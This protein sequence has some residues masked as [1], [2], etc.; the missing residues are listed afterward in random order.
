M[1]SAYDP[2]AHAR[3]LAG[4]GW[5][6]FPLASTKRPL[7]N[8]PDCQSTGGQRPHAYEQCPC[9]A[10]GGTC[11][12]VRAATTDPERIHQWWTRHPDAVVAVATG[13]SNLILIDIDAHRATPPA[14]LARGLLPG[15]DLTTEPVDP[16]TWQNPDAFR[17]GRDSLRLLAQ[18]RGG[19]HPWPADPRHQP[20]TADTPSGGRH[21]WY[22]APAQGLRQALDPY[23]LAWQVD[24]KAG[25]SYGIAPG[26]HAAAG[27][28]RHHTGNPAAPGTPPPWLTREILRV[29]TPRPSTATMAPA[30]AANQSPGTARAAYLQAVIR[31][32]AAQLATLTDGR[33]QALSALAYKVGG[34]LA[35][36]GQ[37]ESD[38]IDQLT[39]AGT[40]SGLTHH[41]ATRT[42]ARALANGAARPLSAPVQT[43]ASTGKV[44]NEGGVRHGSR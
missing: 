36:A 18:L 35:W 17:D 24:L 16:D 25:W 8:C 4:L 42:A 26:A 31:N 5:H 3:H 12:G 32:G 14:D 30:D 9:L 27:H 7:A 39:T 41:E 1:P 15:I 43:R 22:R 23:G 6:V 44:R 19:P 34:Y 40:T 33:K 21:L 20:V 2:E 29:G 11:H 28:Y 38:V 37:T 10:A 13:P